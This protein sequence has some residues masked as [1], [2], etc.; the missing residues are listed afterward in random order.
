MSEVMKI[1]KLGHY[2]V[3]QQK[4]MAKDNSIEFI[5]SKDKETPNL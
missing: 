2:F 4:G 1:E 5:V 3:I